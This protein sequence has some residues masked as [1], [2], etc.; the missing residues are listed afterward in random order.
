[1]EALSPYKCVLHPVLYEEAIAIARE[2][3]SK[4]KTLKETDTT[5]WKKKQAQKKARGR[6]RW[7]KKKK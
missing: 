1:M 4:R 6:N 3:P 2:L 5:K 7:Q